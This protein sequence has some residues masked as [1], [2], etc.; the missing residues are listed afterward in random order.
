MMPIV[1]AARRRAIP[2]GES[3]SRTRSRRLVGMSYEPTETELKQLI[4]RWVAQW[5]EPD[6]D[7]RR[8]LIREVWAEDGYQVMVN[9]PEGVRDTAAHF[10]VPFPAIEI[11]GYDAMYARVTRAYDMFIAA[12]EYA[13]ERGEV[14]R[15]PGAAVA[16]TWLMRSRTDGSVAGSGLEVL[17]FDTDGRV[18]SDHEFVA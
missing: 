9:P 5:N 18:H 14:V 4:D 8:R 11:R 13:F 17:T 1:N 7:E 6:P 16:L 10:G 12:G 2:C 15:H 3:P